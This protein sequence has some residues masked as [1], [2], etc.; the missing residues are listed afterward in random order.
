M[1]DSGSP[2]LSPERETQST[3]SQQVDALDV[4]A[5]TKAALD[6]LHFFTVVKP[7]PFSDEDVPPSRVCKLCLYVLAFWYSF[8]ILTTSVR[9]LALVSPMVSMQ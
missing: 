4:P 1:S 6:I 3:S 2:N 9:Y 8:C 5:N 7:P